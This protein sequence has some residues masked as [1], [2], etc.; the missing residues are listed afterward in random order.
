MRKLEDVVRENFSL[1]P[2]IPVPDTAG[3]GEW[4]AW[5]SLG[6]VRLVSALESTYGVAIAVDEVIA[7]MSIADIRSL[8]Q[9]KGVSAS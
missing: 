6:H 7:L 5:D 4:P 8:L 2:E 9:T 3:P 1:G